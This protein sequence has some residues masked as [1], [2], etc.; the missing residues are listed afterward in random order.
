MS[1]FHA[2][3]DQ[4]SK[5]PS[6]E[7]VDGSVKELGTDDTPRSREKEISN[8]LGEKMMMSRRHCRHWERQDSKQ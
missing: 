6:N 2:E 7:R 4:S 1:T 3:V 8:D 5:S